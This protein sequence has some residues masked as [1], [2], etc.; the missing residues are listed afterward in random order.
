MG[1]QSG[2]RELDH[3]ADWV[4]QV[5][6]PDLLTLFIQAAQGM[7]VIAGITLSG[8]ERVEHK[9]A[10]SS[11]DEETLLVDFLNELVYI[12]EHDSLAFDQFD[13]TI[14]DYRL[15]GTM[16]GATIASVQKEIKAI[17]FHDMQ[18]QTSQDG[19]V[20]EIVMDV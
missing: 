1:T 3:T 11:V 9:I 2:F 6:A 20:V 16:Y 5:W 7:Y 15:S 8:D 4:L 18:I 19:L 12:S 17:T 10:L 14:E 13:L